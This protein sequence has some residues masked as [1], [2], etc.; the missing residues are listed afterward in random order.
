MSELENMIDRRLKGD[1]TISLSGIRL[2]AMAQPKFNPYGEPAILKNL[3]EI[4]LTDTKAVEEGILVCQVGF[5]E[6][7]HELE[8]HI[9]ASNFYK[10]QGDDK[11]SDFH[12][13][14]FR[15]LLDSIL[16]SGDGH[17]TE[18]AFPVISLREEYGVMHMLSLEHTKQYLLRRESKTFDVFTVNPSER[19]T[20]A[21][22]YF[23]LLF[24]VGDNKGIY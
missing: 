6:S 19:Y 12:I 7:F 21:S 4:D 23:E 2:K 10:T 17:E 13:L 3:K 18:T 14:L 16:S 8:F 9:I 20:S 11:K 22:I 15:W 24:P 5:F 1:E